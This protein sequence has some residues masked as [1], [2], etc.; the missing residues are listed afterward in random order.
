ATHPCSHASDGT[1]SC[2]RQSPARRSAPVPSPAPFAPLGRAPWELPKVVFPCFPLWES[3]LA[4]L[5][6]A[7]NFPASTRAPA[8]PRSL[9]SAAR[10]ARSLHNPLPPPPGWLSLAQMLLPESCASPP[11]PSGCTTCLL[12]L[13]FPELS[14]SVPS[15]PPHP[16]TPIGHR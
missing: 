10:R 4:A 6:E 12:A 11:Y 16:P 3:M 7:G 2:V 8:F 5:P 14:T 1:R 9:P 15:R 13:R